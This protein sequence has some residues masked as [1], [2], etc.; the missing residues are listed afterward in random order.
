MNNGSMVSIPSDELLH[1]IKTIIFTVRSTEPDATAN[2]I[3][4]VAVI[5]LAAM[6]ADIAR[7]QKNPNKQAR[8]FGQALSKNI[9]RMACAIP[10][11]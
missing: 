6:G 3:F 8:I 11:L 9:E 10:L 4:D 5:A 2:K 7:Q 1:L